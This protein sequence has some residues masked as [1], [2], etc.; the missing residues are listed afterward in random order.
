MT[1][2]ELGAIAGTALSLVFSYIPGVKDWFDG[3]KP[4]YKRMLMAVLL[5]AVSAAI[6]GLS[7]YGVVDA[8]ECTQPG[9]LGLVN[10]LLA[11]LVANQGTYLIS[12]K[13]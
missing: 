11:A 6:Y 8:V 5:I 13:N 7:C 9:I 3:L 10:V 12:P 1:A 2:E 4:D